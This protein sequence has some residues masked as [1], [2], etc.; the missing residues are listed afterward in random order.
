MDENI[1]KFRVGI[2]VVIA[3]LILGILVFLNSEGWTRQYTIFIKPVTAPGVTVGTPVRKN[4]IL[5]GR[6]KSVKTQDDHVLVGLAI[7]EDESI[8]ENEI[9]SI[10]SESF[11]GDAVVE[12]LPLPKAERGNKVGNNFVINRVAVKRNP[13]EVVDV[14]LNLEADI[15]RT[16]EA[17]RT[18]GQSLNDAG[19]GIRELTDLVQDAFGNEES[20][21]K[22]LVVEFREMSE[23]AQVALDNFDR[24]F[25][26][27]NDIVGDEKLKGE[28]KQ[29]ISSLPK[30]FEE[31]RVTVGDTRKTINSFQSVSGKADENLDN[32]QV[33]T[34]S[35]KEN[36]PDILVQTRES[37]DN[38]NKL[39]AGIQGFTQSLSKLQNSEGTIGKLLNDTEVYDNVL[40]TVENVRAL[41]IK[42]EPLVNDL[43]SFADVLARDPGTIGVR[44]ALD[45]RPGKTGYK[46]T[47]GRDGGL[48]Q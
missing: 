43:R 20:D 27:I 16:L 28:I 4:G 29:S 44:G 32:L 36:G 23:R 46:G 11:L 12:V 1:L 45:R 18:A 6:V 38:V 14:A 10:G 30:I 2:F 22:K 42:L 40:E 15:S 5:I 41:S 17:I 21:F 47:A 19:T 31:V 13:M 48:F 26:N 7:N 35:L 37:L 34:G 39:L 24:V 33:F 3:M 9:C 25:E 8:Y